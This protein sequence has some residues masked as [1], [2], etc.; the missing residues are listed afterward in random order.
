MV[1]KI[2]NKIES[3]FIIYATGKSTALYGKRGQAG[4]A[5]SKL[6]KEAR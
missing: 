2:F 5:Y 3:F 6:G 1:S 4:E